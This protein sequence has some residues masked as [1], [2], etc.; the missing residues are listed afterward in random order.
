MFPKKHGCQDLEDESGSPARPGD[1]WAMLG[2]SDEEGRV[3]HMCF[4]IVRKKKKCNIC[5]TREALPFNGTS[6]RNV[7]FQ[8]VTFLRK[9]FRSGRT[10]QLSLP[11][12]HCLTRLAR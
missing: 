3:D 12:T 10:W 9:C 6:G 4:F 11:P 5:S 2:E 1:E 8:V 7:C